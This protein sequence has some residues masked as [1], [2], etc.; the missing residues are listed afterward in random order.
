MLFNSFEFSL[1]LPIVFALYWLVNNRD[2]KAQNALL[3]IASYVFY[4]WWDWRFLGLIFLSSTIDY[5][6]G[7]KL[8]KTED[9]T[10]RRNLLGWSLFAN[11]GL[12]GLSLIHI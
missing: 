2:L 5:L 7:L 12:L 10:K 3:L 1:F 11:L 9:S 4:G 8:S 6:V